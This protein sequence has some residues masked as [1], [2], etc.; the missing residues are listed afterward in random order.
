MSYEAAIAVRLK[1]LGR[2]DVAPRLIEAHLRSW[3]G[4]LDS[5]SSSLLTDEVKA[6]VSAVDDDPALAEKLAATYGL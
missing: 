5:L 4:P 6:A 2:M 1:N 3:F